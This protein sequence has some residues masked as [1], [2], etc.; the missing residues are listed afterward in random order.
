VDVK[1]A[2]L[3]IHHP[4]HRHADRVSVDPR[5]RP[6]VIQVVRVVYWVVIAREDEL[7]GAPSGCCGA[8]YEADPLEGDP[9]WPPEIRG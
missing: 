6:R 9:M 1:R 4:L 8:R 3:G 2:A 7:G 5:T